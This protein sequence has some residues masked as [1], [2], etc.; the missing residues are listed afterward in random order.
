MTRCLATLFAVVV[1]VVAVLGT[2]IAQST[3]PIQAQEGR[4][5][6]LVF[7]EWRMYSMVQLCR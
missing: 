1:L 5:Y 3:V 2:V 4:G 7:R 6:W